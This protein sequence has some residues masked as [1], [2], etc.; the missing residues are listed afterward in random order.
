[1]CFSPTEYIPE[2]VY[3]YLILNYADKLEIYNVETPEN[4]LYIKHF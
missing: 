1:M 3:A 4:S 2:R